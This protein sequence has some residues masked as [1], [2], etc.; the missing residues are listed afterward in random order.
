MEGRSLFSFSCCVY[1]VSRTPSKWHKVSALGFCMLDWDPC[2]YVYMDLVAIGEEGQ[3]GQ[4]WP[5]SEKW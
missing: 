5:A 1:P 3:H 4:K 2:Y